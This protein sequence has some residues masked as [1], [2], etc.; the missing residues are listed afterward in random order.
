[1]AELLERIDPLKQL[2]VTKLC[3][4]AHLERYQFVSGKLMPGDRVL[5]IACGYG[6]GSKILAENASKVV[7]VDLCKEAIDYARKTYKLPNVEFRVSSIEGFNY[8]KRFDVA[9]CFETIEHVK[10]PEKALQKLYD[11]IKP[12]G[13]LHLSVPNGKYEDGSNQFHLHKFE[14]VD[15]VCLLDNCG[16]EVEK[17]YC[18]HPF[19]GTVLKMIKGNNASRDVGNTK[20][21]IDS[22]PMLPEISAKMYP[23]FLAGTATQ[24]YYIARVA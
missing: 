8:P 20:S 10:D 1:M 22:L 13:K 18:Q 24:L 9:V 2:E 23:S 6:Y 7:G 19:A 17:E 15:M 12:S 3:R 14:R 4:N 16:F 21:F 11:C 5:D